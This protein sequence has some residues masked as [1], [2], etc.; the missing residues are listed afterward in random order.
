MTYCHE[1]P[2]S[3][4]ARLGNMS[5]SVMD[6]DDRGHV[7][8]GLTP[9]EPCPECKE[10]SF[11]EIVLCKG[12]NI[13]AHKGRWYQIVSL[14]LYK[15]QRNGLIRWY[16]AIQ[17]LNKGTPNHSP[18]GQTS[19]N[20]YRKCDMF[21]WRDDLGRLTS[22]V[23]DD[24]WS[25][26]NEGSQG[27]DRGTGRSCQGSGCV[28]RQN[29]RVGNK[30]CSNGRSCRNCCE[31]AQTN[32]APLCSYSSHNAPTFSIASGLMPVSSISY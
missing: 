9:I 27:G 26:K 18:S 17:C 12:T 14:C 24:I 6:H 7:W 16:H 32:G 2:V 21:R 23:V 5:V 28:A 1:P 11:S 13:P 19:G 30:S 20:R 8:R 15:C 25:K 3:G 10:N 4:K 31:R 29:P 22:E